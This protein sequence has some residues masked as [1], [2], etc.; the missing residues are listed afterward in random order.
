M[1][2]THGNT[3]YCHDGIRIHGHLDY[4]RDLKSTVQV[5]FSTHLVEVVV[6]AAG[7]GVE[8]HEVLE[9]GDLPPLPLLRHVSRPE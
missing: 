3:G 6:C 8:E 4:F 9:V 1:V 5:A 7:D 2:S